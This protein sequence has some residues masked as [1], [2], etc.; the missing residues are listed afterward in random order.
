MFRD[1][2]VA[3]VGIHVRHFHDVDGDS[4]RSWKVAEPN[5]QL[6]AFL[7]YNHERHD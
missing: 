4:F 1:S 5:Q 6:T 3:V 2:P 7:K